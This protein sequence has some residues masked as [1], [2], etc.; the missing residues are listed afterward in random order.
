MPATPSWLRRPSTAAATNLLEHTLTQF[1]RHYLVDAHDPKRSRTL[2]SPTPGG[3]LPRDS[4]QPATVIFPDIDAIAAIAHKHGLPLVTGLITPAPCTDPSCIEYGDIVVHSAT[5]FIGGHAAS[6]WAASSWTAQVRLKASGARQHRRPNSQLPRRTADAATPPSRHLHPRHPVGAIPALVIS[7]R[8]NAF[9]LLQGTETLSLR[10]ER[11][12]ENTKKVVC[13][14]AN[15]PQVEKVNHP[16]PDHPDH[17]L[18]SEKY[19]STAALPSSPSTS[20]AAEEAFKFI[21]NTGLL[22]CWQMWPTSESGHPS[23]FHH[24]TAS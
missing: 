17:A 4:G 6:R 3:C 18:R 20:R 23:G 5:K 10:I 19:F 15:Y 24:S 7:P 8:F 14:W 13:S 2:S 1:R 22:L 11:H 16:L 21:D 12:V 9:P